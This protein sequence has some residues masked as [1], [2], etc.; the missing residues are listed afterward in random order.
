MYNENSDRLD[1]RNN[2]LI[3]VYEELPEDPID[4]DEKKMPSLA[5]PRTPSLK[6]KDSSYPYGSI[7]GV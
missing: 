7:S 1:N 3:K 4:S 2:D 6:K 5:R